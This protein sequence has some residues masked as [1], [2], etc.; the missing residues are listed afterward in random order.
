MTDYTKTTDFAAKDSLPSGNANKVI[1]GAEFETEFD[2]IATA[3]STKF[4]NASTVDIN[5]GNI[6]GT[7]IGASAAAAGTFTGVTATSLTSTGDVAVD[8][9]VFKVDTTNDRVGIGTASPSNT[10]EI[11]KAPAMGIGSTSITINTDGAVSLADN[12]TVKFES[13]SVSQGTV[14]YRMTQTLGSGVGVVS[15]YGSAFLDGPSIAFLTNS[16]DIT[17]PDVQVDSTGNLKVLT[18]D[19]ICTND[20][21][22]DTDLFKVDANGSRV[23]IHTAS[24]SYDLHIQSVSATANPTLAVES[25]KTAADSKNPKIRLLGGA[26]NATLSTAEGA[27]GGFVLQNDDSGSID[28][29]GNGQMIFKNDN[30]GS[31]NTMTLK[32][33]TLNIANIPTSSS[34]LSSGDIWNDSGTLKIVS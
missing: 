12:V 17:N 7:T 33:N 29:K 27:A 4:D 24:P 21:T 14:G 3:I 9:S 11:A 5:G 6:D 32:D 23:G 8:T 13:N 22:V 25:T 34:G 19:L 18:A 1:K 15:S 28:I 30:D 20:V 2:N 10:L 31:E 26:T 16:S